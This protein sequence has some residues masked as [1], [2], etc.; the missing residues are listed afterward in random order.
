MEHIQTL[1]QNLPE[2]ET[3]KSDHKNSA[4]RGNTQKELGEQG[5]RLINLIVIQSNNQLQRKLG[6]SRFPPKFFITSNH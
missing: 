4:D 6:F 5:Y 3:Q 2:N 1:E